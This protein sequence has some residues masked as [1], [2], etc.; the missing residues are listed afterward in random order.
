MSG[1]GV[2]PAGSTGL[3]ATGS[4]FGDSTTHQLNE[5]AAISLAGETAASPPVASID[6]ENTITVP[7]CGR[8]ASPTV[9]D[10][11]NASAVAR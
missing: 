6:L 4:T 10:T 11:P 3:A 2:S 1:L 9:S 5:A 8:V 7:T